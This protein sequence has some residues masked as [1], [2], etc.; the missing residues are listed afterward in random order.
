MSKALKNKVKLNDVVSV[1]DFGAVGDGVTDDTLAIQ[2]AVNAL[3]A[4]QTL[5]A[6]GHFLL[7][8]HVNLKK[9]NVVYD[10]RA[11]KFTMTGTGGTAY[12]AGLLIG[13]STGFTP[14]LPTNITILG[15]EYY[16]AGN[17]AVYPIADFNP[18]AI[19]TGSHIQVIGARIYPK[20]SVRAISIQ[21]DNTVSA[22]PGPFIDGVYITGLEIYGDGNAVDGVD[23][24]YAGATGLIRNVSVQGFVFGCKRGVHTYTSNSSTD[25]MIGLTL[26]LDIHNATVAAGELSAVQHAKVNLRARGVTTS[27]FDLVQFSDS[28]CNLSIQGTG[29]SLTNAVTFR[30][31]VAG[32]MGNVVNINVSTSDSNKWAKGLLPQSDYTVYPSINIED[33]TI[34]INSTGFKS[35]FGNVVFRNCTTEIDSPFNLTDSWGDVVSF[36]SGANPVISRRTF[37]SSSGSALYGIDLHNQATITLAAGATAQIFGSVAEFSGMI[38]VNG[39]AGIGDPAMFVMGGAVSYLVGGASAIYSATVGTA[40]KVN[41]Y[42][43]GS[44]YPTVQ[45]NTAGS[46]TLRFFAIRMRNSP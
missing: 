19:G 15:G 7:S 28:E 35:D 14:L 6:E 10:F 21:T 9:S 29:S 13:D 44:L 18:I 12:G 34:G 4:N 40:S 26:D 27:G 38:L 23:I 46:I 36:G 8:T 43:N 16:P 11:A 5:L 22:S 41:V 2:A 1:K 20:Q 45:N 24:G 30:Q 31:Q 42:F 25:Q 17:S 32:T 3:S 37:N 33:A 39:T